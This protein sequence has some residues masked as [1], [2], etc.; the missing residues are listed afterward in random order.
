[1][2]LTTIR[3]AW[4]FG[5]SYLALL[6]ERL[7][8]SFWPLLTI[9]ALYAALGLMG[10]V[11]L[12]GNAGHV[13]LL[14]AFAVAALFAALRL[15]KP[16]HKPQTHEVERAIERASG[17]TDR[18]LDML[19]DQPAGLP[20][21]EA[22]TLW[23]KEMARMAKS[24]QHLRIHL[25]SGSVAAADRFALR[26]GALLLLVIGFVVAGHD[27]PLRLKESFMPDL[28]IGAI[29]SRNTLDAWIVPPDY[30]GLAPVFLAATELNTK[31]TNDAVN[32][33]QG[34]ILKVR[35]ASSARKMQA[36]YGGN[37]Y[38]FTADK[39][40]NY[41][42][43]LPL[44]NAGTIKIRQGFRTVF[45]RDISVIPDN[46][47]SAEILLTQKTPQ[48]A[49]KITYTA[50]DD[51]NVKRI[52][53]IITPYNIISVAG[54]NVMFDIPVST[55][56]REDKTHSEDLSD[57]ILAG[58][59][60]ELTLA[61]E[62]DAGHVTLSNPYP[63]LLP[64]RDFTNTAAKRIIIERKRLFWFNDPISVRLA[65]DTLSDIANHPEYYRGDTV[66]FLALAVAVKRLIYDG[67]DEAVRSVV[68]ML[69]HVA[70]KI[71]DGGLSQSARDLKEALQ[72]L[73]SAL[74]DK[75][76]TEEQLQELANDVT[77]KMQE[78]MQALANEMQQRMAEGKK[79]SAIPPELADKFMQHID[80]GKL[81]EQL[82]DMSKGNGREQMQKM[83]E[84]F[85]NALENLDSKKIDEMTQAQ[86]KAMEALQDMQKLITRQQELMD[87][88]AKKG[89][90]EQ[91]AEE[92]KEQQSIRD[93]L[94]E[95]I[96]KLSEVS[97][98]LPEGLAKADQAMKKAIDALN[99]GDG[100]GSLPAQKEALDALQ[101][102]M[103]QSVSEM[104]KG[105]QQMILSFGMMPK[106][107]NYGEGYDPLGRDDG[108]GNKDDTI[109]LP[110]E[111]ERRRV[112]QIIDELRTRSNDYERPKVERE[113]IERLLD[114]FY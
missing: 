13:V 41:T 72:K 37:K 49:L 42:L 44:N 45:N 100:K 99:K 101:E 18:P 84:F 69:W 53:G 34:S 85:K 9:I 65:T 75:D 66:T 28:G 35:A 111:N 71:E 58:L 21:S 76:S 16:F 79:N 12:F 51:Y 73:S 19:R 5:W 95:A 108:K 50:N 43:E 11:Y 89:D 74:N 25:P 63:I 107:N 86:E 70:L 8:H 29:T 23:H 52:T 54:E 38:T 32:V 47:P 22:V 7:W 24:L 4:V 1:M 6:L 103:D 113:Y 10:V 82:R 20:D 33:P 2:A 93:G 39:N 102:G 94:G 83:A 68:D 80:M 26:N 90:G 15:G 36:I 91:T 17:L 59:E 31:T 114:L 105:M 110:E 98:D 3:Y 61:V 55:S 87:K 40:K 46:A 78:Y 109:Q 30:T 112:Q 77:E 64:E 81:M 57:H 27:A 104:A 60:A 62:D 56:T 97:S 96:R 106:G 88:T 92:A 14:A 67:D 48:S